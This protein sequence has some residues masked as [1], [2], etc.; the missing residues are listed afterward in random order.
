MIRPANG[1]KWLFLAVLWFAA[2]VYALFF[3]HAT[4][5]PPFKH[6]EQLR[7]FGLWFGQMWLIIKYYF[8]RGQLLPLKRLL[9]GAFLLA[10]LMELIPLFLPVPAHFLL[11]LSAD[12]AGMMIALAFGWRIQKARL[13]YRSNSA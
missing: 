7:H 4:T 11:N 3:T 8:S 13:N 2:T 9:T 6:F 5:P 12:I 1:H 10:C